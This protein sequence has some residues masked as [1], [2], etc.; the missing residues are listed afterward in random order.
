MERG[1]EMTFVDARNSRAW[2]EATTKLPG[3]IRVPADEAEKHL[4]DIRRDHLV[5]TYCT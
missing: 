1:E 3:A 5:V 4:A 2:G